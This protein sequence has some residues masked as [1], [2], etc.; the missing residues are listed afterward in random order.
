MELQLH[1][2]MELSTFFST[3]IP[4]IFLGLGGS[5]LCLSILACC[6]TAKGKV[7][8]L[9]MVSIKKLANASVIHSRDP[10]SNLGIGKKTFSYSVCVAFEL[11]SVGC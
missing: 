3:T 5:I 1:K 8:L 7:V 4:F 10:G 2:Y 6:C 9:Y 11:K